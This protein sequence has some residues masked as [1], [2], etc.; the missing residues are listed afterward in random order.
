[1]N[2]KVGA[3]AELSRCV[4]Q[5]SYEIDAGG[6]K[7]RLVFKYPSNFYAATIKN[8]KLEASDWAAPPSDEDESVNGGGDSEDEG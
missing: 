1:M 7:L 4:T 3:K 8:E 5:G 2:S 6:N